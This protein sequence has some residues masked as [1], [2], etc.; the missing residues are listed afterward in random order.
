MGV[1]ALA[2]EVSYCVDNVEK[3]KDSEN[4]GYDFEKVLDGV[5]FDVYS[6]SSLCQ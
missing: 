3:Q 6:D 1:S 5:V 2:Y 4:E